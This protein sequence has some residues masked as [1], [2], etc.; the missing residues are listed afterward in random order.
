MVPTRSAINSQL[1]GISAVWGMGSPSGRRKI[2]VTANQSASPPTMPAS[3]IARI[4]PPHQEA[5]KGKDV[6]ARKTA[7]RRTMRAIRRWRGA[8]ELTA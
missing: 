7:A 5:R 3:A 4:Q 8:G 2:A 1:A 6:M